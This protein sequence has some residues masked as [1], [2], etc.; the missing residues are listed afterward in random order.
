MSES[1]EV[2]GE[3]SAT[4][5]GSNPNGRNAPPAV[6]CALYAMSGT[7]VAYAATRHG[8]TE[9]Y[10]G[11]STVD[12]PG[13]SILAAHASP[14]RCRYSH[15]VQA[16]SSLGS[17]GL[18]PV[19]EQAGAGSEHSRSTPLSPYA[20]TGTDGAPYCGTDGGISLRAGYVLPGT[21]AAYGTSRS[22]GSD[23]EREG[24]AVL[25]ASDS[26]EGV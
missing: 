13:Q 15:G 22:E 8:H 14:T 12:Q 25:C 6:L 19:G 4:D 7:D 24:R 18:V 3:I 10:A 21:D 17:C 26:F 2:F 23:G 9:Q 11:C 20:R 1:L 5:D 16:T